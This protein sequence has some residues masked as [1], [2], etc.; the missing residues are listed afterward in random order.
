MY[1]GRL[2]SDSHPSS[3]HTVPCLVDALANCY[4]FQGEMIV[5]GDDTLTQEMA[6][7]I[8]EQE[9]GALMQT[10]ALLDLD[11]RI[12][13]TTYVVRQ[14]DGSFGTL[15]PIVG[16]PTRA[17]TVSTLAPIAPGTPTA[18]PVMGTPAPFTPGEPTLFPTSLPPVRTPRPST[19]GMPTPPDSL[20]PFGGGTP[21]ASPVRVRSGESGIEKVDWWGWLLVAVGGLSLLVCCFTFLSNFCGGPRKR[22]AT[23]EDDEPDYE[24]GDNQTVDEDAYVPPGMGTPTDF[25][26][27]PVAAAS[28][29]LMQANSGHLGTVGEH[30]VYEEEDELEEEESEE[31]E[32]SYDE[33][34]GVDTFENDEYEE[35]GT[36][37]DEEEYTDEYDEETLDQSQ[38][39]GD[40]QPYNAA[41]P[42]HQRGAGANWGQQYSVG[43]GSY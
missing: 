20:P 1:Y 15:P 39:D 12:L 26:V 14:E 37:E 16:V 8:I 28:P 9:V 18:A 2:C 38:E 34:E 33:E 29:P 19:D 17:P 13:S 11:P 5:F 23:K 27:A 31:E 30:E 6:N 32:E 4:T 41:P 24:S 22:L 35:E 43:G 7:D 21:T 42:P 3:F 36:Y 25:G 40:V 10:G